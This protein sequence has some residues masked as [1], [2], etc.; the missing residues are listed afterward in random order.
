MHSHSHG[1]GHGHSHAHG[2]YDIA[3][4][5]G[6]ALN[7]IFIVVEVIFGLLS[8]SMALLA[9]AGHNFSDVVG[10]LIAWAASYATRLKPTHRRTY[11]WR[12]ASILG[13]LTNS[14]ILF[15]ALGAMTLEA[16]RRLMNPVEVHA[17]TVITVALIGVVINALTA[18]MFMKGRKH[19]LNIRGAFLHMAA[20]A[21]VSLGVVFA[22][23][24]IGY[25]GLLW[26]DPAVS[27]A[28]VVVILIGTW[29]LF[30]ASFNLAMDAVPE[31]VDVHEVRNYLESL[32][33]VEEVHDLHIWAMSTT[34]TALTAHLLK[35]SH[36]NDDKLLTDASE[37]LH[38][39][40]H[41]GHV[42]LQYERS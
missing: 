32:P 13:A 19:D 40:F 10:L 4:A 28:I 23:M 42:T 21:G 17:H 36:E 7:V 29:S 8:D 2:S 27:L 33:G 1:H 5:V 3:F 41:I 31:H 12:K 38:H 35:P 34:E 24:L 14:V 39:R 16:V 22:G 15:T 9:D 30:R 11:G 6:I 20:D 37:A 25:T 18:A 26:I